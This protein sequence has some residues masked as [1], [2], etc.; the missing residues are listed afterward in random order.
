MHC[1]VPP[2]IQAA[3]ENDD[4]NDVFIQ[5]FARVMNFGPLLGVRGTSALEQEE[6]EDGD[7][8]KRSKPDHPADQATSSNTSSSTCQTPVSEA[9]ELLKRRA[10]YS[11]AFRRSLH[12]SGYPTPHPVAEQYVKLWKEI[13][14]DQVNYWQITPH[15]YEVAATAIEAMALCVERA[16]IPHA[17]FLKLLDTAFDSFFHASSFDPCTMDYVILFH[18][19]MEPLKASKSNYWI[20]MLLCEYIRKKNA[21]RTDH[22][23]PL[24]TYPIDLCVAGQT[25]LTKIIT[26]TASRPLHIL[27]ADDFIGSGAQVAAVFNMARRAAI[28]AVG[29]Q[30]RHLILR[31]HVLAAVISQ[32]FLDGTSEMFDLLTKRDSDS[33]TTITYF[34]C[35]L[36]L[37]NSVQR[38]LKGKPGS[39]MI[40]YLKG[41]YDPQSITHDLVYFDHKIPKPGTIGKALIVDGLI[42]YDVPVG[43][44]PRP[45]VHVPGQDSSR[46]L[47]EKHQAAVRAVEPDNT[48][49]LQEAW[50]PQL[51]IPFIVGLNQLTNGDGDYFWTEAWYEEHL[52]P[53][54]AEEEEQQQQQV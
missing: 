16:H 25:P 11:K 32:S 4:Q 41:Y 1:W 33:A 28:R 27:Y 31:V 21:E 8:N 23:K 36:R 44:K 18:Y 13:F 24:L 30:Q 48:E 35:G 52:F 9:V 20:A 38:E 2:H 29:E 39:E 26:T 53:A 10:T 43:A 54:I 14:Y 47:I 42:S 3:N 12:R 15:Q 45:Q 37:H 6:E 50:E 49:R 34:H 19:G 5:N 46:E 40:D 7:A 22:T 17:T 51:L